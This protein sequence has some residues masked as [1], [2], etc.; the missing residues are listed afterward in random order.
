MGAANVKPI[1]AAAP[2]DV[3]DQ[4]FMQW[5]IAGHGAGAASYRP[6]GVA[7]A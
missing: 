6:S 7:A 1:A 3:N 2:A 4:M 5:V